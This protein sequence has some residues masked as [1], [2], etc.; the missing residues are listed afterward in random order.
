[1]LRFV[2]TLALGLLACAVPALVRAQLPDPVQV[3]TGALAGVAGRDPAVRVYRG[4]PFAQPPVGELRWQ[5]PQPPLPWSGVRQA[6]TFSAACMQQLVGARPPWTEAFMHQGT[7]DEDCLYLN[8]WTAAPSADAKR[9][10]LVYL[11]GGGFSEGSGSVAVYDG[12]ALARKGLV[13]VTVNYRLGVFGFLAHPELTAASDHR[14][15]GNY[16]LLDQVAAL[17]WVQRNIGAFGGDPGRV[18]VAGQSAGAMSVYLL[19]A[20]PLAKGL[21]HRAIIQSGPGALAAFGMVSTRSMT[22]PRTDAEQ[23]GLAFARESGAASLRDLRALPAETLLVARPGGPPRRFGPVVDGWFLPD[24]PTAVYARGQQHD[25]PL[26]TGMNADEASAFPG[27][28]TLAAVDFQR[29]A[30]ERYGDQADAFLRLYPATTDAEAGASQQQS[31]RDLGLV[32]LGRLVADRAATGHTS[33]WLYLHQRGIPW[34]AHPEFGAFHTAEVPYVFNTLD[35]LDRPWTPLDRLL[36]DRMSS[37]WVHFVATGDPNGT[38]LPAWPSATFP[39]PPFM[40]FDEPLVARPL[41]DADRW[42]FFA[43]FLQR[44]AAP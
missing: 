43:A 29:Q 14:A 27:Y 15:S 19:T 37:Y 7:A 1:M 25:V 3:E 2:R 4:V 26:L 10:V 33:A 6:D 8:V 28:G 9:P 13:V 44:Q 42:A 30:R 12:E 11:H 20:S 32:A 18:A 22:R 31:L 24:E 39:A 36:A 38:G 21:F 35:L 23:D 34:P 5:A 40:V 16:G 17:R 41:P